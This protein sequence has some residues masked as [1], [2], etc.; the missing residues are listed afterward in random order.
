MAI[1]HVLVFLVNLIALL[2]SVI[3]N[4][5][6]AV[7][8]SIDC[9][10]NGSSTY[11]H[12]NSILWS[13]DDAYI[14]N[15]HESQALQ[16][17]DTEDDWSTSIRI[18]PTLK[19]NCYTIPVDKAG[20]RILVRASF[21]HW[22]FY[23]N[24]TSPTFELQF[25]GTYWATVNKP[26]IASYE[27]IYIAKQNTTTIC[28][29][30][31]EDDQIPFISALEIRSLHFNMYSHINPN[32]ALLLAN[33]IYDGANQTLRYPNDAYDRI[34]EPVTVVHKI[35]LRHLCFDFRNALTTSG[36]YWGIGLTTR[37]LPDDKN[38]PIYITTYFSE[39]DKTVKR[40]VQVWIDSK[41]YGQPVVPPF[42]S[43]A[44][45]YITNMTASSNTNF[46]V[47]AADDSSIPPLINAYEVYSIAGPLAQGTKTK[48]G[49]YVPNSFQ[50]ACIM[51][52]VLV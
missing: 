24:K 23:D 45:V 22:G 12:K 47:Q 32:Y 15:K 28:L 52:Y 5:S 36:T 11:K 13:G 26:N 10:F 30:R 27:A 51:A 7:F 49:T 46:S 2:F 3:I 21:Y 31:V 42:G 33:R 6:G 29:A 18:F 19:K 37:G 1:T 35:I 25:D 20:Q 38:V 16:Y 43:V 34:W 8:L 4:P 48:D 9:G 40:S 14:N 41:H 39:V 17:M 44:V 50:T